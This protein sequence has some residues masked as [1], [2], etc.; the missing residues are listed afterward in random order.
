MLSHYDAAKHNYGN[1]ELYVL[2]GTSHNYF[3]QLVEV[4][5]CFLRAITRDV[6]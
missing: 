5:S 6:I 4:F 3:S 1:N 2:I